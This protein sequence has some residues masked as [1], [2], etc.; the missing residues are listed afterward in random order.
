MPD[1]MPTPTTAE[2]A[3]AQKP[4]R[5]AFIETTLWDSIRVGRSRSIEARAPYVTTSNNIVDIVLRGDGRRIGLGLRIEEV[6]GV[7]RMLVGVLARRAAVVDEPPLAETSM[8]PPAASPPRD[9]RPRHSGDEIRRPGQ[10]PSSW[11]TATHGARRS[12]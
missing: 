9:H 10:P 7:V 8:E 5:P 11:Q 3:A 12:G 6:E 2:I 1:D 4:T